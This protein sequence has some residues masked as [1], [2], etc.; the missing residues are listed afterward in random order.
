ML[1]SQAQERMSRATDRRRGC[2]MYSTSIRLW[3]GKHKRP[4][5]SNAAAP[6]QR[7]VGEAK[8]VFGHKSVVSAGK[9]HSS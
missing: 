2:T 8:Q 5:K 1:G 3:L 4:S 9:G 7:L 6:R